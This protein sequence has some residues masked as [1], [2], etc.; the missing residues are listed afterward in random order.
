[1]SDAAGT[2]LIADAGPGAG[3]GHLSR[4][5]A[6]A[7]ALRAQGLEPRCL[8]RGAAE[9]AERD[10]VGWQPVSG[11]S[12]PP[13]A[14]AVVLDSYTIDPDAA[15]RLADRS[16]LVLMHRG[17]GAEEAAVVVSPVAE[18]GP[19]AADGISLEGF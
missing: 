11:K 12:E 16:A 3:L 6:V 2:V 17:A 8:A 15:R 19:R 7:V 18:D 14:A 9:A 5:G 1:M 4:T 10:W 13:E